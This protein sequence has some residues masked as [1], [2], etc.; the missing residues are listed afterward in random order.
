MC[1]FLVPNKKVT[2]E[3]GAGKALSDALPRAKAALP[4]VPIP[5]ASPLLLSTLSTDAA[6]Q[7]C[8]DFCPAGLCRLNLY[9]NEKRCY[10]PSVTA[11]N[12]SFSRS[13]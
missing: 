9:P 1:Y 13:V 8:S 3:I 6:G 12:S 4:Y 2:K 5:A 11:R 10:S 7:K